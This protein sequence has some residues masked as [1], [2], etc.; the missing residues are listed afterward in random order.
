MVNPYIVSVENVDVAQDHKKITLNIGL[1]TVYG[2]Y[3][4]GIEV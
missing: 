4:L 1:T 3:T 2:K